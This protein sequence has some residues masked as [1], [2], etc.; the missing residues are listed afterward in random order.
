MMLTFIL[1]IEDEEKRK[2]VQ[3][4]FDM[5]YKHMM[6]C[7]MSILKHHHDAQDAVQDSFYNIT[8]TYDLFLIPDSPSTAALVHIYVRNAAINIYN[9]NKTR[10]KVIAF[11][12]DMEKA[13]ADREDISA[14]V[15]QN[16]VDQETERIIR[17]AVNQLDIECRDLIYLKYYYNMRNVDIAR[18]MN[19]AVGL[20]NGRIFRAKSKLKEI[21]GEDGY[22]RL[23]L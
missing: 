15:Q 1:S 8:A 18:V 6:A 3:S 2:V 19:I 7:A 14:N 13:T 5:Y 9:K 22:E 10:S 21:L 12:D 11:Y 20:V 23:K 4:I 16:A 17:R